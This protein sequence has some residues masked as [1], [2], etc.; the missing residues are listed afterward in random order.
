MSADSRREFLK[1]SALVGVGALLGPA[2]ASWWSGWPAASAI[3]QPQGATAEQRL[4]ELNL[5]L[6]PANP[7]SPTL[8]PA[9]RVGNILY[10]SGH[11]PRADD[12]GR[13]TGK[14]GADM[15]V[16]EGK[17]AARTVALQVLGVV[18]RELGS[19]DKVVRVVKVLG[20]VNCTPD[21]TESP[22]VINGFSE[23]LIQVFGE[24]AGKG[25]RS[26]VGMVALPGNIPVEVEAIF[27]VAV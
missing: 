12:G 27:E 4:K 22:Q 9:V 20:M 13:I 6:P 17:A 18:R 5:V 15:T 1:N 19:L 23:L 21:F 3:A 10:V 2:A 14:V 16:A 25:A 26:A 7:P 11:G 24:S 8:V